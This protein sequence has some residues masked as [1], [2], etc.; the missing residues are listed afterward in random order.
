[1]VRNEKS[2]MKVFCNKV[3]VCSSYKTLIIVLAKN[4]MMKKEILFVI[5]T[6]LTLLGSVLAIGQSV[7]AQ[8]D[9][10]GGDQQGSDKPNISCDPITG[11]PMQNK[12]GGM[13]HHPGRAGEVHCVRATGLCVQSSS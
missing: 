7:L 6:M 3:T 5:P 13:E 2:V 10:Q 4:N 1:M 8:S 11:N 12:C 9:N